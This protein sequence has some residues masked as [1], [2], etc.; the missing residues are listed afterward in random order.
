MAAVTDVPSGS[1]RHLAQHF[2]NLQQN[3]ACLTRDAATNI[4]VMSIQIKTPPQGF[5]HYPSFR[6]DN[7]GPLLIVMLHSFISAFSFLYARLLSHKNENKKNKPSMVNVRK[8]K[9]RAFREIRRPSSTSESERSEN[10]SISRAKDAASAASA[11]AAPA[12]LPR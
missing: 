10:G 12:D 4:R 1:S 3:N 7:I 9:H 6:D 2:H 11:P 5:H 8:R